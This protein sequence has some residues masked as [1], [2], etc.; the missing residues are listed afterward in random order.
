MWPGCAPRACKSAFKRLQKSGGTSAIT[1]TGGGRGESGDA[2][3]EG[4]GSDGD[5]KGGEAEEDL[6]VNVPSRG[7]AP[8][9]SKALRDIAEVKG[10][11][12]AMETSSA[13]TC[14]PASRPKNSAKG[15]V[16]V[17]QNSS[18][19]RSAST[20]AD[21]AVMGKGRREKRPRVDQELS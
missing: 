9:Q 2:M 4:S 20:P 19:E 15:Y 3:V 12:L 8:A 7:T 10:S 21:S 16:Y 5:T 13:S 1:I 18:D 11:G 6:D 17:E 14:A